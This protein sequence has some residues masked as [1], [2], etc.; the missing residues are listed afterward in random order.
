MTDAVSAL[1]GWLR[2]EDGFTL[3]AHVSPDGD[4]IGSS[5]ALFCILR[6]MG[7]RAQIVCEQRVPLLYDFLPY[8]DMIRQPENA[9]RLPNAIAIDCADVGRMGRAAELFDFA[10]TT[11]NIDHHR[12][13]SAYGNYV[14]KDDTASAT[15]ELIYAIWKELGAI[16][17]R[18]AAVAR[19]IACC[20]YT[21][22]STDTGNF[23]YSNTTPETFRVAAD[24]LETG[25]DIADIN[26]KVYRTVPL[27]KTRLL[28][29]VLSS[30]RLFED[31]RI[32]AALVM[33]S[34]LAY[35]GASAEDVEGVIDS[36]RDVN[37]V[38]IAI[39]LREGRDGTY[40]ASMRSKQYADVSAIARIYGGGG[41]LRAAGCTMEGEAQALLDK[42]IAAAKDAL[43]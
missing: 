43:R 39:L 13:N 3:I 23:A 38:E 17:R 22:I 28:G 42:L 18:D 21:A 30:M 33:Q 7:K 14:V 5:L 12:T 16:A 34:D 8:A 40:K 27:G 26:R 25:I 9:E 4:T 1:A 10:S 35:F 19:E 20:L 41:H 37:T 29:Y 6:A 36:I 24:L 15:G 31:G 11:G 32:G 2:R